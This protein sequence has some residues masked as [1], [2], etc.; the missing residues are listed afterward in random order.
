M[1]IDIHTSDE[2]GD[3]LTLLE[4]LKIEW[5]GRR[6]IVPSGFK[7]DG[8]SVPEFLWSTVS[9]AVDP[10]TIRGAV[11]H[12]YAYRHHPDGWTRADADAMFYDIIRQ[13]GLS[14]WRAN[15]V[16]YGVRWFG[17]GAWDAII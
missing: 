14:W 6:L 10:R 7:S 17:G 12:D 16:Y 4:P 1:K 3:I 11:A 15:K 5:K 8:A 2:S 9:P 13:D